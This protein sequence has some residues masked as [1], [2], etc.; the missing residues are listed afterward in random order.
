M[1]TQ[2][3]LASLARAQHSKGLWC[4]EGASNKIAERISVALQRA[5]ARAVLRRLPGGS[6][7]VDVP[8]GIDPGGEEVA[9]DSESSDL[10]DEAGD[11]DMTS[12]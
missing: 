10:D 5:A 7:A 9:E 4:P 2:E 11:V 12:T 8:H 3:V 6:D 1:E